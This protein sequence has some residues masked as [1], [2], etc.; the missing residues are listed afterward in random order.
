M[1][2]LKLLFMVYK[3]GCVNLILSMLRV[4]EADRISL[5]KM[6]FHPWINEGFDEPPR[7]YLAVPQPVSEI[8]IR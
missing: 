8:G 1:F 7:C 5:S 2:S 4:N 3:L 6:R